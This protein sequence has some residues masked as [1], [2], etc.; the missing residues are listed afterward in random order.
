[1]YSLEP[2]FSSAIPFLCSCLYVLHFST[3][4][5]SVFNVSGVLVGTA[6]IVPG[7]FGVSYKDKNITDLME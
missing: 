2:G 7:K 1:M 5:S 6:N 4:D 3:P